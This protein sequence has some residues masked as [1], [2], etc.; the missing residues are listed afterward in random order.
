MSSVI[1]ILGL[2]AA[3]VYTDNGWFYVAAGALGSLSFLVVALVASVAAITASNIKKT[4][5]RITRRF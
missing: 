5:N 1:L 2:V 4:N 3:G